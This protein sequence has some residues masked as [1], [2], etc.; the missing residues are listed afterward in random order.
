MRILSNLFAVLLFFAC[1]GFVVVF[2]MPEMEKRRS[3]DIKT[4]TSTSTTNLSSETKEKE[5]KNVP[6]PGKLHP[7]VEKAK[8]KLIDRVKEK[9]INMIVTDGH[10]SKE[11]QNSLYEKGRSKDGDIVTHVKGGGSYHNYG[12]AIDFA[13][14]LDNGD[15]IWDMDYDGNGNGKSDWM[16]I[17]AVAKDLGFEW[18]GDWASFKD[19]PHLQMDFGY[20]IYE[21]KGG[22]RPVVE[23]FQ[24]DQQSSK[25]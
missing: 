17:V 8:N 9:G 11:E 20:S 3:T 5:K 1:V 19:Y 21:L 6:L 18:G 12:L 2:L 16:E 25:S 13:L 7:N 10:R 24:K 4:V 14:Q 22:K 15:V 23:N